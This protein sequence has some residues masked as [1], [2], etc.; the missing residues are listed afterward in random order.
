MTAVVLRERAGFGASPFSDLGDAE[1]EDLDERRAVGPRGE[2][3]VRRLEVAVDDAERVRLGDAP[4]TP[5]GRSS[6][7]SATAS[8][9]ALRDEVAEVAALEVLHHHVGRAG[10][11]RADVDDAGD[12][13]ALELHGRARLAE[14]ARDRLGVP[15]PSGSRNLS[16]TRC[17]ELEV[18]APRRRRPSRRRRGRARRGTC[19]PGVA[20]LG[21]SIRRRGAGM[22]GEW[23]RERAEATGKGGVTRVSTIA[24]W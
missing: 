2:E 17:V 1:V 6:T 7:A 4:R 9:P 19:P 10:L 11:E 14:E 18:R 21:R 24:G 8:A 12:V 22:G 3:E 20:R 16:A 13:L 23:S 5:G 15:S